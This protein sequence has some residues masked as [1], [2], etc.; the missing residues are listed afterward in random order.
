VSH[1]GT[2]IP[3]AAGRRFVTSIGSWWPAGHPLARSRAILVAIAVFAF[4]FLLTDLI[5]PGPLTYFDVTSVASGGTPLALAAVG[6]TLVILSGGFDMS[7]GAVVSLINTVLATSMNGA[8]AHASVL[9]WTAI[10]IGVGM[11]VGAFN[12]FFIGFLRLQPIVVT[13]STM[14]IVQGGTLLVMEKP[15]GAI[16]P[17]LGDFYM[18]NAIPNLLPASVV[19]L[20][21][22]L[23]LW[24]WLKRTRYGVALYAVGSEGGSAATTGIRVPHVI[25]ATYVLAGG[26]YGLAGVFVSGQI[27]SGDPLVGNSL[28]LSIFAAV[29]IGGTRL[30]GGK[31]SPV[32]SV[33]GAFILMII[34]N[35][36]LALNVSAYFATIAEGCVLLIAVLLGS[37]SRHSV[38]SAQIQHALAI[39]WARQGRLLVSQR[40]ATDRRLAFAAQRGAAALTSVAQPSLL[41]RNAEVIRQSAPAYICL[42]IVLVVSQFVLGNVFSNFSYWNSLLVLSSFLVV[43]ALGQG[44][45]ILTG[46]LDMSLPWNIAFSGVVL[47]GMVN[48]SDAALLYAVPLVLLLGAAVGLVN[49]FGVVMLGLSPIVVTLAMNGILQGAAL[50]YSNGTPAGYSSPWLRWFMTAHI[51]GVTPV[52]AFLFA[53]VI[54][55]TLLLVRTSFGRR[56]YAVGNS[57]EAARL[58]GVPTGRLLI[59]VYVLSGLCAALVGILLTGFSGQASLG[60]GDDYL[61]PSIAVVVVGGA[62][63]T[64]GRGHYLGMV[65]GTLLLTALQT[66]LAGTT[67][68]YAFRAILFGCVVLVAVIALRER[69][70]S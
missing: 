50:L 52:V 61:L 67:L 35:I 33:F 34:V 6:Q 16:S 66:L 39:V 40:D 70:N 27:G 30:G 56:V 45:V 31:G 3:N 9:L 24:A 44:A 14:F 42:V 26:V 20:V 55:G 43:L 63:I 60:M 23:L 57:L 13:I 4:L 10:G 19:L 53:F 2:V 29:V 46:G 54:A 17:S 12:G 58:S 15:G 28:M 41:R 68:P 32:G 37:L 51:S 25:F 49:G 38:L 21:V 62:L 65:G 5:S 8:D 36:L 22:V 47:A 7:A 64:G 18:G 69:R 59:S 11:G 48:G 1:A